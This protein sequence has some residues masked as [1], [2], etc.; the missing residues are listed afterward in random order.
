MVTVHSLRVR[1]GPLINYTYL[2]VNRASKEAL[3]VDPGAEQEIVL[4][5]ID[6][7][8]STIKGI[9]LTH[10][11]KDHTALAG[12]FAEAFDAP[13]YMN[14]TEQLFHGFECP[15]LQL[16]SP[17]SVFQAGGMDVF[18]WHT[19]G[20][21]KGGVCYQVQD[22]LF[23]GDTL[24]VEGCGMCFGP[25]GDPLDMYHSLQQLRLYIDP[26]VSIYP[27]HSYGIEPGVSFQYVLR[28]NIY[29]HF[30]EPDAFVSFRMRKHQRNLFNF[31]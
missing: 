6:E 3:L 30:K 2:V 22:H 27:G 29:F 26:S 31:K 15:N 28:E 13:V 9:L 23:T 12:F 17:G 18:P 21:T 7:T 25:G 16:F 19:P 20:H 10:H 24:F 14:I 11:H 8:G 5:R 4:K 1:K